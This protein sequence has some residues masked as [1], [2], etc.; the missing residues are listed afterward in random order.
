MEIDPRDKCYKAYLHMIIIIHV[1]TQ[2]IIDIH[3]CKYTIAI[4]LHKYI[5]LHEFANTVFRP[6]IGYLYKLVICTHT[7]EVQMFMQ[8]H[9]AWQMYI[10][11]HVY[12]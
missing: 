5:G 10:L 1:H 4:L 11:R 7:A 6:S 9:C 3:K 2:M 8:S 12:Y